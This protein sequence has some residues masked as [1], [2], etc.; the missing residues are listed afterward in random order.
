MFQKHPK[1][2]QREA[3]GKPMFQKHPKELQREARGKPKMPEGAT[4]VTKKRPTEAPGPTKSIHKWPKEFENA[5][6]H[7]THKTLRFFLLS[8]CKSEPIVQVTQ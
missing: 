2:L 1:E 7:E 8:A 6:D 3:R 4:T 5:L